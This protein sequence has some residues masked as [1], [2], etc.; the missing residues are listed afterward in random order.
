MSSL[1]THTY[2]QAYIHALS[3]CHALL[4]VLL[5]QSAASGNSGGGASGRRDY[6]PPHIQQLLDQERH[7]YDHRGSPLR[8]PVYRKVMVG[9]GA[10]PLGYDGSPLP[11]NLN[12]GQCTLHYWRYP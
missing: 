1:H 7:S 8:R 4:S 2:I 9:G 10:P 11:V 6:Y 12:A 3:L 5:G